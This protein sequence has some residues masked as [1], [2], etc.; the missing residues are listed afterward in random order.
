[1][2]VVIDTGP[3]NS[4]DKI[5]G[6]GFYTR[7]LIK[8]LALLKIKGFTIDGID[9]KTQE[10][11]KYDLL[12]IPYFNPF[13]I[14]LPL[15][16][17]VK[18]VITIHDTTPLIYPDHYPPGVK[19]KI[20][21]ELNK[22]LLKKVDHVI[23]DTESSKKDIVRFLDIPQEKISVIYLAQRE[24]FKKITN[25]KSLKIVKDKFKLPEKFALYIGD[26]N[27]NKNL[28]TLVKTCKIA[29]IPL[30]IVGKQAISTDFDRE[31]IENQPLI[32]FLKLC[33]GNSEIIRTGFVTDE[34][35]VLLCNLASLYIQPSYYEGFG[36]PVLEALACG[37]PVIIAK[38]QSLVEISQG[39]CLI[40][41]PFDPK[42]FAE[43]INLILT[44]STIRRDLLI[45]GNALVKKYSWIKTAQ[46]TYEV[47]KDVLNQ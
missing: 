31:H 14:N 40:A 13:F 22:L 2:R 28:I 45:K 11:S 1:M 6:V 46:A 43:K 24:Q 18:N 35:V 16:K 29:K 42:D 9:P 36:L 23:T 44:K 27:Y 47:Y 21:L 26:V 19:G 34:E 5:R 39:A 38:T 17:S 3:L 33:E 10:L 8:H 32:E 30:V 15:R 25:I 20:K 7:E 4:G 12:H 41:D 37:T